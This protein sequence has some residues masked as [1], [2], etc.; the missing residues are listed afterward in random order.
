MPLRA[1]LNP[2]S[3]SRSGS[4]ARR[5]RNCIEGSIQETRLMAPPTNCLAP[6]GAEQILTGLLKGVK[7]GV[8][9]RFD[10]SA[11]GVSRYA[12]PDSKWAWRSAGHSGPDPK[13]AEERSDEAPETERQSQPQARTATDR[14]TSLRQARVI[15]FA[16]RVPLLYQQ[17]ACCVIKTLSRSGVAA[18]RS[19]AEWRLDCRKVRW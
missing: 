5:R 6:I 3:P 2:R 16:N 17:S 7:S 12:V 15:R 14:A 13:A 11:G 9:H 4:P 18:L 10:A 19:L 8:L 1:K